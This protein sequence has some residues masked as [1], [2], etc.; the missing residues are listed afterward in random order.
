[1]DNYFYQELPLIENDQCYSRLLTIYKFFKNKIFRLKHFKLK[2]RSPVPEFNGDIYFPHSRITIQQHL[3]DYNFIK[4]KILPY[5]E[6]ML[7][8]AIKPTEN[9]IKFY[10]KY[11]NKINKNLNKLLC[12]N[13]EIEEM[14]CFI[15]VSPGKRKTPSFT[16]QPI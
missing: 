11:K 13:N 3:S 14:N 4:N 12:I 15:S 7:L 5:I 8:C 6:R 16:F 9:D 2:R 1:M 10:N